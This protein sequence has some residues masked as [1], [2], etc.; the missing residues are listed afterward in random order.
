MGTKAYRKIQLGI[1]TTKGTETNSTILWR[2]TGVPNDD[3]TLSW[4][5]EDIGYVS[6]VGRTYVPQKL[7]GFTFN[8]TPATYELLPYLLACGVE[9][10]VTP[11]A[12]GSG[13]GKIYTYTFPTTAV[14][15]IKSATLEGGDD[16]GEEQMLYSYVKR[17]KLSGKPGE[18]LMC[19]AD[20]V[21]RSLAP[22]TF[23]TS[24][25]IPAVNEILFQKGS[26]YIDAVGGT[27]GATQVTAALVGLDLTIDTG[28]IP[29]F[30][31]DGSVEFTNE[32]HT[33]EGMNI[34][35]DLTFEHV[36][37]AVT[38]KAAW[39]AQ[40]PRQIQLKF[41]GPALSTAGTTYSYYSLV[42]NLNGSWEKFDVLSDTDGNDTVTGTFRAHYNATSTKFATITV[43][44]QTAAL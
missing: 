38:E 10:V 16:S 17:I 19:E 9:N 39:R 41:T 35:A 14:K 26:L 42:V 7:A 1:E 27:Q 37:S 33:R 29:L 32:K 13:S 4:P 12:D 2:G 20:W 36:A 11:A 3:M 31:A 30:S 18:A 28:W 15:T 25:A 6:G 23:T 34:K 5:E 43:V 40:T 44:N 8:S 24:V 22:G 21:G